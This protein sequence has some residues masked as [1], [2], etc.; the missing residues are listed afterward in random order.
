VSYLQ[1]K[2]YRERRCVFCDRVF[3]TLEGVRGHM[4]DKQHVRIKFEP[5]SASELGA[6]WS[7]ALVPVYDRVRAARAIP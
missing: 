5:L 6:S 3:G 1:R 7:R 2:L 4:R